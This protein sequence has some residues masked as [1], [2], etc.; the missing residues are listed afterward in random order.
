M[1]WI[2]R[3]GENKKA[4]SLK[5]M[6]DVIYR[7]TKAIFRNTYYFH[8]YYKKKLYDNV[9]LLESKNGS[10]LAGNIFH[11]LEELTS[12]DY[13]D[14]KI[15]LSCLKR[16]K[17]DI[18]GQLELYGIKNVKMIRTNSYRYYKYLAMAK[19][20]FT[21]TSFQRNYIKKEGQII[22]NTWHGTPLKK[23]GRDVLNRV[24]AMGNV[25]RNLLAADYLVY[26]NDYMKEKMVQAYELT[27][28]YQGTILCEGYP[29]NSVFFDKNAGQHI[30][31]ELGLE[32]KQ[33]Y[34]YMPTWRGTITKKK[35]GHF[36]DMMMYFFEPLDRELTDDQVFYVKLH[37]FAR[38]KFDLSQYKHI[39]EY[40]NQYDAYEFM[41]MCDA[42]VTDY[43]SVFY[44][45]ANSKKKIILFAY[46]ETDYLRER[47][48]YVDLRDYPFPIV[49][50]V[51][52]LLYELNT[53]KNYDDT[54][55]LKE[56]CTYD[57]AN[58]ANRI[59]RHVIKGEKVCKEE[60]LVKNG[61]ENILLYGS[62]LAKNG[63]TTSL[64]NLFKNVDLA[65]KN[66]YVCF[67]EMALKRM[68]RRVEQLPEQVGVLPISSGEHYTFMEALSFLIYMNWNKDWGFAKRYIDRLYKR[69]LRKH[70]A[71]VKLDYAVQFAGYEKK[72]IRMFQC[73]DIPR[74]IYV[75]NDMVEEMKTRKNQHYLTLRSA[76]QSYDK[77]AVV[78]KDIVPATVSISGKEDNIV[79]VNN[80]HAHDE[81]VE[82]SM[83]EVTFDPDTKSNTPYDELLE[84]LD[85]DVKKFITIGR[86]SPEKGHMMLMKA[87]EEFSKEYPDTY[88]IIIGGHGKLYRETLNYAKDSEANIIIIKSM[89][90][91]MTILRKCDFFILSSYYEGLG[92]T[93][94][95]ADSLGIPTMSTDIVGPQGFMREH[96][97]YLVEPSSEGILSGMKAYMDGK[98]KAMNVDYTAYNRNAVKQFER[99]FVKKENRK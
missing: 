54:K 98:V 22:T 25:Q 6:F 33:V 12:G 13:Q 17:A 92:L 95:E 10:D 60:K 52:D 80:C 87:F 39:K 99:L 15:C 42:L 58:A 93:M 84:I 49:K 14:Y 7:K 61:K 77:V 26:P 9:I 11:I 86:F 35:T 59:C 51:K 76:Y 36:I 81:I 88:L 75:H 79:V 68:P 5:A 19:Y 46:D 82:R 50:T 21:D 2:S 85:S 56:C 47:G 37:P 97:G 3:E 8:Y 55:F 41:N 62:S 70:W 78:T 29:R 63:L 48:L 73:F 66:Y 28:L 1:L 38:R 43:S 67:R 31:K 94:L 96:G 91:P 65:D 40:P 90:N 64:L 34:M 24:Y 89:K 18:R 23:M 53:P 72:V 57:N 27:Q 4:M 30:R 69:E 45:F 16:K 74:V 44:D 71:D 83:L 20:L 32:G